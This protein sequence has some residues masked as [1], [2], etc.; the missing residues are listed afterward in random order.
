M[1]RMDRIEAAHLL[2]VPVDADA[3]QVRRAYRI[4][5]RVAHPD[6]GG[7]P[8]H[9]AL[10]T[11]ARRTM[12]RPPRPR[13]IGDVP[14]PPPRPP[15]TAMIRVPHRLSLLAMGALGAIALVLAPLIGAGAPAAAL[16]AGIGSAAWAVIAAR[17]VLRSGADAG[18][19]IVVLAWM[20]LP[21]AA[22]QLA[23]S[24]LVGSGIVN[25]LPLLA[26]PFVA[27]IALVNPGAGLWRPVSRPPG[28]V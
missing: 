14:A 2:G 26:L 18:H 22:A 8:T 17:M 16:A 6:A 15:V 1:E 28:P 27:V 4:W 24:L 10:L 23:V 3:A 25:V 12:L 13:P 20:W 7:D 11:Q 21:L 5:A 19:R 9:F